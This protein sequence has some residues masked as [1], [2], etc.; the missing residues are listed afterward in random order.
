MATRIK[1]SELEQRIL[2]RVFLSRDGFE[3]VEDLLA[4]I[5]ADRNQFVDALEN[6]EGE[7]YL[8][9]SSLGGSVV[10]ASEDPI[11]LAVPDMHL[12]PSMILSHRV[13]HC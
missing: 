10:V 12:R 4:A 7:G 11:G 6:L 3:R 9:V 1:M 2:D 8:S 5:G 13:G